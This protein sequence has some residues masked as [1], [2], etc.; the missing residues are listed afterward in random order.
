M[1]RSGQYDVGVEKPFDAAPQDLRSK[2]LNRVTI[3]TPSTIKPRHNIS[4]SAFVDPS[5]GSRTALWSQNGPWK[6]NWHQNRFW[7]M[8]I[9]LRILT[10]DMP[11]FELIKNALYNSPSWATNMWRLLWDQTII[12]VIHLSIS[13]FMQYRVMLHR[14]ITG[15]YCIHVYGGLSFITLHYSYSPRTTRNRS[16]E[17]H[18]SGEI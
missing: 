6:M 17:A 3:L 7:W 16:S 15:L 14:V 10:G 5:N 2:K 12:R 4:H 1:P 11:D 9:W 8:M 18:S 13:C